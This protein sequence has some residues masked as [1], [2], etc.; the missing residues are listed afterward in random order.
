MRE[1][2]E[3]KIAGK[4]D[5]TAIL[6]AGGKSRRMGCDKAMLPFEGGTLLE[7]QI[8]KLRQLH[9][10][11]ILISGGGYCVPGAQT[12]PD[13]FPD[14]GPIGGIYSCMQQAHGSACLVL[15][16]DTP[17]VPVSV[18][19]KLCEK[20]LSG[21]SEITILRTKD[22]DIEPLIGIY[23]TGIA[24][25]LLQQIRAQN[26]S[27]RHLVRLVSTAFFDVDDEL[28]C[29]NCNRPEDYQRLRWRKT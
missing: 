3:L 25:L 24:E 29:F 14:C 12:V 11:Q 26:F 22:G 6:L 5:L 21:D 17:L 20:H 13:I 18:L 2:T 1:M 23:N 4:P 27:V 9:L 7:W 16:V 8:W 10:E 28:A 15:S 19:E